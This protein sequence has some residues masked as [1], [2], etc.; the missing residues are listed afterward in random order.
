MN[1]AKCLFSSRR[2]PP[3]EYEVSRDDRVCVR[4]LRDSVLVRNY[5]A[6]IKMT[7][8]RPLDRAE[9]TASSLFSAFSM[10]ADGRHRH[11]IGLALNLQNAV[12]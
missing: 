1:E 8:K 12:V 11:G 7:F 9:K 10:G 2:F 3:E 4:G 5:Q 6:V